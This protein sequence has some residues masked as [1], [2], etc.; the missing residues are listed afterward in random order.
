MNDEDMN[1][2]GGVGES[3]ATAPTDA[4]GGDEDDAGANDDGD[5]DDED[6]DVSS[7]LEV[8][9]DFYLRPF[10]VVMVSLLFRRARKISLFGLRHFLVCCTFTFSCD[11]FVP[12]LVFHGRSCRSKT[13]CGCVCLLTVIC[14]VCLP[15]PLPRRLNSVQYPIGDLDKTKAVTYWQRPESAP[16]TGTRAADISCWQIFRFIQPVYGGAERLLT[17]RFNFRKKAISR[18]LTQNSLGFYVDLEKVNPIPAWPCG[19]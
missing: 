14:V 4:V 13:H 3:K 7:V 5:D 18:S 6:E 15:G 12:S 19:V 11:N 16:R 10:Q 8:V 17:A 9:E 2:E 1:Q